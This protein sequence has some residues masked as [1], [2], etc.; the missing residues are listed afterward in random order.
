MS[1]KK[2]SNLRYQEIKS[3]SVFC[4]LQATEN[5]KH[6]NSPWNQPVKQRCC[7][8]PFKIVA[9]PKA[10]TRVETTSF[11]HFKIQN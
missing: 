1:N 7:F 11:K 10:L 4:F 6:K 9:Q 8:Y 2:D 3:S 5:D